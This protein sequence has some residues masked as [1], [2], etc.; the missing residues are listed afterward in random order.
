VASNVS[1]VNNIPN[2]PL[3]NFT[4]SGFVGI[5]TAAVV[6][7]TPV[8]TTT[9]LP[10]SPLGTYPI[11]IAQGTMQTA[12]Y[13]FSNVPGV[14]TITTGGPTP[15]F[16]LSASPQQ[17]TMLSGQTRQSVIML[18]PVNFYQGLVKLSCG[19][20]PA[21]VSCVFS[22]ATLA[23]DGTGTPTQTAL[24]ISTSSTPIVGALRPISNAPIYG[25]AVF[26]LPGG[27]ALFLLVSKRRQNGGS[28][29]NLNLMV[30]FLLL[31][32][33]VGVTACG[34]S[35]KASTA[36]PGDAAPGTSTIAV[37]VTGADKTSHT[38]NLS[39]TVE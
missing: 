26:Y 30:L 17:L 13:T 9:A 31:A 10:G 11:S 12:N 8:M 35:S 14:L 36:A 38:I 25:A 4:L 5:D 7:G 1:R 20:L 29:R 32:G 6:S 21:N 19:T 23:P 39:I 24:T 37:T 27:L 18:S 15:D 3:T 2:P 16:S 22:P 34:G 33:T 28:T